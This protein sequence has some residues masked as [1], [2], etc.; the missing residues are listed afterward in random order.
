MRDPVI[1]FTVVGQYMPDE[2]DFVITYY[3]CPTYS[4]S[5]DIPK[6]K[7]TIIKGG[8]QALYKDAKDIMTV[9]PDNNFSCLTKLPETQTTD[10]IERNKE[11]KEFLT[12][13]FV[14]FKLV[15]FGYLDGTM[16][17][18]YFYSHKSFSRLI[19][20]VVE[21]IEFMYENSVDEKY[22]K[23]LTTTISRCQNIEELKFILDHCAKNDV[24]KSKWEE[25]LYGIYSE[26]NN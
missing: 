22:L 20:Y 11:I 21:G 2:K 4:D 6:I 8:K 10:E 24:L 3:R 23:L 12:K 13:Y 5:E 14:L 9:I 26:N 16:L 25:D 17:E 7:F 19:D 1:G 18:D 15:W